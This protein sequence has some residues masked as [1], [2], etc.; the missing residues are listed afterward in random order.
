M[1]PQD[2]RTPDR[3]ASQW[4]EVGATAIDPR[5]PASKAVE[6]NNAMVTI[7]VGSPVQVFRVHTHIIRRSTF[8]QKSLLSSFKQGKGATVRLENEAPHILS[9]YINWLYTALVPCNPRASEAYHAQ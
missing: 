9:V 4:T 8:F 3:N 6:L 7:Q 5:I 2:P 1:T